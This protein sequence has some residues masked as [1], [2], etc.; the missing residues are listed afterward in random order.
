MVARTL[1]SACSGRPLALLGA[2]AEAGVRPPRETET[3]P[4]IHKLAAAAI[5]VAT[6]LLGC[7]VGV[8]AAEVK[9]LCAN[10]MRAVLTELQP[11]FERTTGHRVTASFGE[12]G[13]LRKRI[14]DG[15]RGCPTRC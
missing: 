15:E 13:D 7:G 11:Q 8:D 1:T 3:E 6:L 2:A 4:M 9:V 10:G 5:I 12:A 14:Q